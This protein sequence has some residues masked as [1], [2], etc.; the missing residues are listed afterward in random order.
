LLAVTDAAA[1]SHHIDGTLLLVQ[2]GTTR[3]GAL[4][5]ALEIL[6]FT[7]ARMLG[8]VVN[9]VDMSYTNYYSYHYYDAQGERGAKHKRS[10]SGELRQSQAR[11]DDAGNSLVAFSSPVQPVTR[12]VLARAPLS[13]APSRSTATN[14][15]GKR[16]PRIRIVEDPSAVQEATAFF[17][18]AGQTTYSAFEFGFDAPVPAQRGTT[19]GNGQNDR[20]D[21]LDQVSAAQRIGYTILRTLDRMGFVQSGNGLGPHVVSFSRVTVVGHL[22]VYEVDAEWQAFSVLDLARPEVIAQLSDTTRRSIKAFMQGGLT[23]VVNQNRPSAKPIVGSSTVSGF[24]AG[25]VAW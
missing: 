4:T 11:S 21:A 20:G 9:R 5:R 10:R 19:G 14:E 12:N 8:V 23:Y 2:P 22:V 6:G 15:A 18:S 1:L 17:D 3:R 7:N 24:W 25:R 13:P 16:M